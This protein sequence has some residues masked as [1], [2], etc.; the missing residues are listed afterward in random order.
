DA[1]HHAQSVGQRIDDFLAMPGYRV[2]GSSYL[3]PAMTCAIGCR[4]WG[5][6]GVL[7]VQRR[8]TLVMRPNRVFA[9]LA[10]LALLSACGDRPDPAAPGTGEASQESPRPVADDHASATSAEFRS[11]VETLIEDMLERSPEWAIYEGRYENA[12]RV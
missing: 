7:R 8:E 9:W 1:E 11:F 5:R 12:G 4:T 2:H 6:M 10:V 3:N